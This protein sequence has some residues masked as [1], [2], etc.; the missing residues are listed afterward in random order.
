MADVGKSSA[1]GHQ[2]A[3]GGHIPLVSL[4]AHNPLA[5][6][7]GMRASHRSGGLFDAVRKPW[8][9]LLHESSRGPLAVPAN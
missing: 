2:R 7:E 1:E 4:T 3:V 9:C 5:T 8:M 6:G